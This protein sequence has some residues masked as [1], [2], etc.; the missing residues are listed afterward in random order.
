MTGRSVGVFLAGCLLVVLCVGVGSA[1][2]SAEDPPSAESVTA[3]GDTNDSAPYAEAGLDQTVPVGAVVYLDAY[4]SRA[5]EGNLVA[6]RWR[7]EHPNGTA[8]LPDCSRC[9]QTQFRP[10]D[11]GEYVVNLT[12]EDEAGRTATDTMYVTVQAGTPPNATLSGPDTMGINETARFTLD[13][14]TDVGQLQSVE[15]YVDGSYRRGEFLDTDSITRS[16]LF[17]PNATGRHV[18]VAVVRNDNGTARTVRQA[19]TVRDSATFA[20]DIYAAPEKLRYS[21]PYWSGTRTTRTER[22]AGGELQP[23]FTVTNTGS[24][25]DTQTITVTFPSGTGP[26]MKAKRLTLAPGQTKKFPE[27]ETGSGS[28]VF[29][30]YFSHRVGSSLSGPQTLAVESDTDKET[31]TVDVYDP[32]EFDVTIQ[33]MVESGGSHDLT[34]KVTNTGG[35]ADT[36]D[37]KWKTDRTGPYT[38]GGTVEYNLQLNSGESKTLTYTE[39]LLNEGDDTTYT[40]TS[41]DDSDSRTIPYSGGGGGGGGGGCGQPDNCIYVYPS[42]SNAEIEAGTYENF[43]VSMNIGGDSWKQATWLSMTD[44]EHPYKVS[45]SKMLTN[46]DGD[47]GSVVMS[48]PYV[49]GFD[50]DGDARGK[51]FIDIKDDVADIYTGTGV[52]DIVPPENG[53]GGGNPGG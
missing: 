10:A 13:A 22:P 3:T 15:W 53:G 6:Y 2:V 23:A 38:Y 42:T 17:S 40:V 51:A 47:K 8:I 9:E 33:K 4:G 21:R 41:N 12:V 49:A 35:R 45:P 50:A 31:L 39:S 29:D 34:V 25:A 30:D 1:A 7:V 28:Y 37:I 36:Q 11:S 43:D 46:Y 14:R 48:D 32:A 18:I 26:L 24:T 5:A 27:L 52:V 20:V 44:S 16:L 19:V